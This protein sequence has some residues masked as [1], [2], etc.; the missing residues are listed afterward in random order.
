MQSLEELDLYFMHQALKEAEKAFFEKEVPVGAVLVCKN[1]IIAKGHNQV[2]LLKDAT[3]HAEILALT[4]GSAALDDWRL[5][6]ATL[7]CTLEPCLMCAGAML[8][9]RLKRLVWATE[10]LRLGVNGS[11]IDVFQKKHPFHQISITKNIL[12][13]ES[14]LLLK[15]F[16][17]KK[18]KEQKKDG[19]EVF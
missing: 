16:F 6:D 4:A 5:T 11:W 12:K 17:Q 3:A 15:A 9:C 10:D 13:D 7:Y 1:K 18:R 8:S 14:A 2:E 19:V